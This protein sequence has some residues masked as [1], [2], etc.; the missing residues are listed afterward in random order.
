M[1]IAVASGK[2]GTG[3]TTISVALAEAV[4]SD[5]LLLDCDVEEPNAHIFLNTQNVQS[6]NVTAL[7]PVI[8]EKKCTFCG[9]CG[10]ICEFNA[11][12]VLKADIMVF[13][14]LCHSCGGCALICPEGAVS[15]EKRVIGKIE[16]GMSGEI[17]FIEGRLDVGRAMSPPII[18]EVKKHINTKKTNIID[19]PPGTA[20]P[21]VTAVNGA[22]YVM[23]VTE[24]TPFGL[25]DLKLA[26]DTVRQLD[27]PYGVLINRCD[28]GDMGVE[29]YCEYEKIEVLMKI[30]ENMKIAKAYSKGETLI[31]AAPEM[32]QD[33]LAMI[34]HIA[35]G[36]K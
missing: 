1:I 2:G 26:V 7:I 10:E 33:I 32:K 35:R 22:D 3:K 4:G 24:A 34:D 8:D 20:C 12:A 9:K 19:C 31:S 18:R 27:I 25:H 11:I 21:A 14:E 30:P 15:E 23:L 36:V 13:E 17:E 6:E 29:N 16:K 5:V 28:S